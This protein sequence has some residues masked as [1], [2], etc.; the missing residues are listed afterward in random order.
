[1]S[2]ESATVYEHLVVKDGVA[3]IA[4]SRYKVIHL[5]AEKLAYGWSPEELQYQHPDLSLGQVYAALAYHADHRRELEEAIEQDL[6]DFRATR[7]ASGDSSL[8]QRL[9][10]PRSPR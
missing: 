1:M 9:R 8:R 10:S 6:A 7:A 3:R 5:V 4:G 2:T